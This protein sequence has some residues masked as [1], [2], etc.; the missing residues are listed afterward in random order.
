MPPA[1]IRSFR[2]TTARL[3]ALA[4]LIAA[5]LAMQALRV[6]GHADRDHHDGHT[7]GHAHPV[8]VHLT[9]FDGTAADA[10]PAV[11]LTS[12]GITDDGPLPPLALALLAPVLTWPGRNPSPT[13]ALHTPRT[14]RNRLTSPPSARAPPHPLHRPLY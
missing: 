12:E 14:P 4:Y 7:S 2:P 3:L 6:H 10:A 8:Q 5:L 11:D 9:Y 13:W 1:A